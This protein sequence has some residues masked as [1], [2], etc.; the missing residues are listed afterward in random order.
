VERFLVSEADALVGTMRNDRRMNETVYGV[1]LRPVLRNVIHHGDEVDLMVFHR[2]SCSRPAAA[3]A[4]DEAIIQA[5]RP[6]R[7]GAGVDG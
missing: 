4:V 2:R 1:G 6:R 5:L 7:D 3:S